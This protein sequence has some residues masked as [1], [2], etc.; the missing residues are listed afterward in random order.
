MTMDNMVEYLKNRGFDASKKYDSRSCTYIF[1]ISKD[2]VTYSEEFKYPATNSWTEKDRLQKEFLVS[3]EEGYT[4]AKERHSNENTS[5]RTCKTEWTDPTSG[6]TYSYDWGYDRFP[7]KFKPKYVPI[8]EMLRIENRKE[9]NYNTMFNPNRKF[10]IKDVIFNPPATI[11]FWEDGT[12]TVVKAGEYDMFDPEKGLAMA[13]TKKA[14]GNKGNYYNMIRKWVE[15]YGLDAV[16]CEFDLSDAIARHIDMTRE[17]LG[18][19]EAI[20]KGFKDGIKS[21]GDSDERN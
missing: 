18:F 11:V 3:I 20:S 19:G 10:A 15:P 16:N 8:E 1:D 7:G 12:K 17:M 2:G 14:L 5:L 9:T 4:I 6:K 13:I 21:A